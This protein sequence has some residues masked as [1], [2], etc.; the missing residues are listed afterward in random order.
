MCNSMRC[1]RQP[2]RGHG[3]SIRTWPLD[4][5]N[6]I[7]GTTLLLDCLPPGQRYGASHRDSRLSSRFPPNFTK[8][9]TARSTVKISAQLK[10]GMNHHIIPQVLGQKYPNLSQNWRPGGAPKWHEKFNQ[11]IF[12][13]FLTHK[14]LHRHNGALDAVGPVGQIYGLFFKC[15]V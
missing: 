6:S 10:K 4:P 8:T 12:P 7:F 13:P 5:Q 9:T 11:P 1:Q 3:F 2:T 15:E 14:N